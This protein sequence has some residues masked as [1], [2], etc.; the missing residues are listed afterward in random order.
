MSKAKRKRILRESERRA[1]EA[2]AVESV[3]S[4]RRIIITVSIIFIVIIAIII[5]INHYFSEDQ[6]YLRIDVIS[7][8]GEIISMDYF[9]RRCYATGSD[10]LGALTNITREMILRKEAEAAG[11]SITPE[12]I[13]N[14]L[15]EIASGQDEQITQSE[16]KEWLRQRLNESKLSEDE[17]RDITATQIISEIFYDLISEATPNTAE[18]VHLHVILTDTEE[19]AE[20]TRARWASGESFSDLA[21]EVSFDA[22]SRDNGGDIGWVPRGVIYESRYDEEI[23]TLDIGVISKPLAYYD[24]SVTDASSPS[25]VNYY[26]MMVSEKSGSREIDEQYLDTVHNNAFDQWISQMFSEHDIKYHGIKNGFDSE[27]YAWINWQLQKLI[28]D[29]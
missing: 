14:K 27:T 11:I 17:Y 23:F 6:K 19:E 7:V 26:L 29:K 25:Y 12:A 9:V 21:R 28:G 16:F 13:D 1:A 5:G 8:D 4:S 18:Q 15:I 2:Q 22:T 10:P 3:W 20:I 24:T